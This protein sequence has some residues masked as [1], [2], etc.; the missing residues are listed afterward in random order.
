MRLCQKEKFCEKKGK[1]GKKRERKYCSAQWSE[2]VTK[3]FWSSEQI[4]V[5]LSF[6]EALGYILS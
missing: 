3:P 1:K 2:G 6:L 4:E 5:N